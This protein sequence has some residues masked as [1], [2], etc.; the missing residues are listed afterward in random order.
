MHEK[1]IN[2]LALPQ[3]GA[4]NAKKKLQNHETKHEVPHSVNHK[5]KQ[6][7]NNTRTTAL[8]RS[9]A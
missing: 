2:K 7:K 4:H 8:E 9:V 3:R 5:A 1:P 6:N